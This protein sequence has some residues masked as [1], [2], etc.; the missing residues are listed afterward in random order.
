MYIWEVV[1]KGCMEWW[2][3]PRMERLNVPEYLQK[4]ERKKSPG[5]GQETRGG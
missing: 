1:R 3:G 4:F 5:L 2:V